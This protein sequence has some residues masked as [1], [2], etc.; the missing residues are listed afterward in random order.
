MGILSAIFKGIIAVGDVL[1][2]MDSQAEKIEKKINK[3]KTLDESMDEVERQLL[4]GK[5]IN[6]RIYKK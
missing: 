1:V 5:S 4:G 2:E 6:E 3:G